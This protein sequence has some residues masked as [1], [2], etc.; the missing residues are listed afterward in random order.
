V[1]LDDRSPGGPGIYSRPRRSFRPLIAF[2]LVIIVAAGSGAA[3]LQYLGPPPPPRKPIVAPPAPPK[4][5]DEV[6]KP[7]P[8]QPIADPDPRLEEAS[9]LGPD[10]PLPKRGADGREPAAYY[11]A[12]PQNPGPLPR[13]ALVV[14]GVGLDAQLSRQAIALPYQIDLAF[15]AHAR[16]SMDDLARA[17]RAAGHECLVSIPLL[18]T[19]LMPPPYRQEDIFAS[20]VLEANKSNLE[21][22][23]SNVRG[24]VGATNASD[25]QSGHEFAESTPAPFAKLVGDIEARGLLFLDARIDQSQDE[26]IGPALV[27]PLPQDPHLRRVTVDINISPQG[28]PEISPSAIEDNLGSLERQAAYSRSAVGLISLATSSDRDK[29]R[30][31]EEIADWARSVLN[32]HDIKLVPLSYIDP[33]PPPIVPPPAPPP[34]SDQAQ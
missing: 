13:I 34:A 30:T 8:A 29:A 2:W 33:P 21:R 32:R 20:G 14:D 18:V 7:P 12:R 22:A 28:G 24:C 10:R 5:K 26:P 6:D 17:A 9:S 11:A 3:Y 1:A 27:P 15:S 31:L 19:G 16:D 25:G 4:P 23:L